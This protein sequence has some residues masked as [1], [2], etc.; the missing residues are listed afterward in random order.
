MEPATTVVMN[1]DGA[2][3]LGGGADVLKSGSIKTAN[4]WIIAQDENKHAV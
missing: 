3:T 1:D 4:D 2:F